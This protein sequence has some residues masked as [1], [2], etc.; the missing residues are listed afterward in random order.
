MKTSFLKFVAVALFCALSVVKADTLDNTQLSDYVITR[1][2]FTNELMALPLFSGSGVSVTSNTEFVRSVN[3]KVVGLK[4]ATGSRTVTVSDS[5]TFSFD[6]AESP[7]VD[8]YY[9][10]SAFKAY[11]TF[12]D[13]GLKQL[14]DDLTNSVNRTIGAP[15]SVLL[16]GGGSLKT[17]SGYLCGITDT[18]DVSFYAYTNGNDSSTV[19]VTCDRGDLLFLQGDR[20]MRSKRN[21]YTLDVGNGPPLVY[22]ASNYTVS[23]A[24]LFNKTEAVVDPTSPT[25]SIVTQYPFVECAKQLFSQPA[26]T[27]VSP[28]NAVRCIIS[29]SNNKSYCAMH[30]DSNV[31][32]PTFASS[33]QTHEEIDFGSAEFERVLTYS[34]F[35]VLSNMIERALQ[36]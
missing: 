21:S 14:C 12:T 29:S 5:Y 15:V 27:V 22:Q 32:M 18:S 28:T 26:G 10:V 9:G 35:V 6:V 8:G 20:T 7:Y 24:L 33:A 13:S 1:S 16:V 11:L 19:N 4:A 2:N 34:D 31:S 23:F 3:G 30:D 36:H 17:I 25:P